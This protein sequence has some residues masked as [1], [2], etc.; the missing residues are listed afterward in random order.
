MLTLNDIRFDITYNNEKHNK[1]DIIIKVDAT[2]INSSLNDILLCIS[3]IMRDPSWSV[4]D[5]IDI[6]EDPNGISINLIYQNFSLATITS[7]FENINDYIRIKDNRVIF[8]T[9]IKLVPFTNNKYSIFYEDDS[10]V[11]EEVD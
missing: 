8:D 2:D 9:S 6:K 10:E 11:F 7:S 5:E 4:Y 1:Y 3:K